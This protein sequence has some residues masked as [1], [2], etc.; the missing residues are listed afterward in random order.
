[1]ENS[2]DYKND[3]FISYSRKDYVDEYNNVIPGNEV[4]KIKEALTEAGITF[5]MDEKGIVP[6]EDFAAKILKYIKACK[7]FVFI[8]SAAA[9][10]SEWTRKEIACA[11]MY[12]KEVIPLLLDDSP[13]HDSV[14]LRIADLDQIDYYVNPEKGL[15]KLITSIKTHLNKLEEEERR[16]K[17]EEERRKEIE[18]KKNEDVKRRK[19]EE[20]RQRKE[21]QKQL[22]EAI[23]TSVIDL[24]IEETKLDLDRT[25]LL[26]KTEKVMDIAQRESLKTEITESSPI[27]K[28]SQAEIKK[29]QE[30]VAELKTEQ[31]SFEEQKKAVLKKLA[32]KDSEI[33]L[34]REEV[35]SQRQD[36]IV[37]QSDNHRWVHIV[38]GLIILALIS[39]ICVRSC[40][41]HNPTIII[42]NDSISITNDS[43]NLAKE[44]V[45][46]DS[47]LEFHVD[48]IK[49]KMI[50]VEGGTF[51][52]GAQKAD[53]SGQ[54]YDSEA[55]GDEE[56]VHKVTLSSFYMSEVVVT[57]ALWKAVMGTTVGQQRD[58]AN[59]ECPMGGEGGEYPMYYV[60]WNECQEFIKKLNV[61]IGKSFR[62]PTEAEWEYAAR[63]GKKSLGYKYSGS[64]TIGDV[65]WYWKNSGDNYLKGSD[66]DWDWDKIKKNNC[67]THPVKQLSP[68]ELG[69][70]D[71]S[72]NV[73][74]W[75]ED[76]YEP[77]SSYRVLRGGSWGDYARGCRVSNRLNYDPDDRHSGIGFRLVLP[78]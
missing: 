68:N 65:A 25:K 52:M 24:N 64:N 30:K 42:A 47:I 19:E 2:I 59:P 6:G 5:W 29:L 23:R 10:Q 18:R 50:K 55:W 4:S 12:K 3:V 78:Q 34:L 57:Q 27:R 36:P 44:T 60:N 37:S 1:M 41:K 21:Q 8:S 76:L 66:D 13:F 22:V 38:Y 9:N 28:K 56:R 31:D 14:I 26:V 54:N 16:K 62:L 70:Y 45:V 67:K 7:I 71:M 43:I 40:G 58:K 49:F 46:V 35:G 32:E 33:V 77:S 53:P 72:G 51:L 61:V 48:S 69:I 75:C 11:L 20:E 74:E 15:E 73:W 17:E 63:G 39:V